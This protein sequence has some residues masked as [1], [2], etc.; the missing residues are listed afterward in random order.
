MCCC[1]LCH[2]PVGSSLGVPPVGTLGR[3]TLLPPLPQQSQLLG[4]GRVGVC[5]CVGGG[6]QLG[7]EVEAAVFRGG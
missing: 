7:Q 1:I 4:E 6:C 5:V 3:S 2:V